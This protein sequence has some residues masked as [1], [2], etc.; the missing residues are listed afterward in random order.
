MEE[1]KP[2]AGSS[3]PQVQQQ[4]PA[5]MPSNVPSQEAMAQAAPKQKKTLMIIVVALVI[6]VAL[7]SFFAYATIANS[8]ES[9]LSKA[10]INLR[11]AQ[12]LTTK[13]A[14]DIDDGEGTTITMNGEASVLFEPVQMSFSAELDVLLTR[15]GAEVMYV[16]GNYYVKVDGLAGLEDLLGL[17]LGTSGLAGS[18]GGAVPSELGTVADSISEIVSELDGQWIEI[19]GSVAREAGFELDAV[20]STVQS[21]YRNLSNIENALTINQ[22]YGDETLDGVDTLKLE[23]GL[24]PASAQQLL[25]DVFSGITIGDQTL[26]R[27]EAQKELEDVF[28]NYNAQTDV[29][30]VWI[31]K[32]NNQIVQMQVTVGEG[33]N[34]QVITLQMSNYN[35]VEQ[36]SAPENPKTLLEVTALF[37]KLMTQ[38]DTLDVDTSDLIDLPI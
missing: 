21:N 32:S 14:A 26:T 23:I 22:V 8:P 25:V 33:T 38:L 6:L 27:E 31:D 9:R 19:Q 20:L 35:S 12:S 29:F 18:S 2:E 5:P 24:D 16:D 10:L 13:L 36:R 11:D 4:M 1:Q 3:Q 17:Y 30:Q 34:D 28:D 37:T 15:I 7:G